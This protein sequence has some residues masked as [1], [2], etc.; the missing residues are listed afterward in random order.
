MARFVVEYTP[1]QL[2]HAPRNWYV[3]PY[4]QSSPIV[5][6]TTKQEAIAYARSLPQ[7][8]SGTGV[9][10]AV[11]VGWIHAPDTEPLTFQISRT[12]PIEDRRSPRDA[13]H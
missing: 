4:T 8:F 1:P 9:S 13:I 6:F 3:S 2:A 7:E 11:Q 10:M 5:V 12:R